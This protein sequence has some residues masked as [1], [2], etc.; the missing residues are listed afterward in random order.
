MTNGQHRTGYFMIVDGG[1]NDGIDHC[2]PQ[3]VLLSERSDG[4]EQNARGEQP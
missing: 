4:G 1:L 2:K 3:V